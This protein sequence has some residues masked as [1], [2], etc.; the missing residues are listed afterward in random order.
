MAD[1]DERRVAMLDD[2]NTMRGNR[3]DD[4][5]PDER[6]RSARRMAVLSLVLALLWGLGLFSLMAALLGGGSYAYLRGN[7]SRATFPRIALAGTVLGAV[8]F[9]LTLALA[10][11]G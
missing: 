10:L 4:A 2:L 5:T 1:E 7:D 9:V 8:G 3:T 6:L 11:R